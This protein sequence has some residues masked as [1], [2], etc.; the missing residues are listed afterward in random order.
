MDA[1]PISVLFLANSETINA[2]SPVVEGR[3]LTLE[4]RKS[5]SGKPGFYDRETGTQWNIEGRAEAGPL[6]GKELRRLDSHMS[7]WYGWVSYFPRTTIY[8][9]DRLASRTAMTR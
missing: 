5:P 3:T 4:V 7:Q 8:G 9:Q 6:V 1:T 2:V